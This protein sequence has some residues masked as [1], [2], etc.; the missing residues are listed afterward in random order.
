[1]GG[2]VVPENAEVDV[3][4][5]GGADFENACVPCCYSPLLVGTAEGDVGVEGEGEGVGCLWGGDCG[6]WGVDVSKTSSC[7]G[8]VGCWW[9]GVYSRIHDEMT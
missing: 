4:G 9:R 8:D 2:G 6:G 5:G 1:M 7:D 3:L